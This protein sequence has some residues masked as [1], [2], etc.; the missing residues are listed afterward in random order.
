MHEID[1]KIVIEEDYE[2]PD[3]DAT[4]LKLDY[5]IESPVQRN[6]LVKKIVE[7]L[8]PQRLTN[9]YLEILADYIIFAMTKEE[10]K[11]KNINTDNRM[12]TINKREISFQGLVGK[13]ENGE[14]GIYNL[15]TEDKNIIFTPKISI[16]EEDLEEIPALRQLRAAIEQVEKL[17]KTARG[18]RK[19]L[20]KKQIIQMRQD[21]YVIKTSY[22]QPVYC[23][24]AV[25]NFNSMRFDDD[26][27][28][29]DCGRSFKR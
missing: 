8:P 1:D 7:S 29:K 25:K 2:S 28:R 23:L 22:K 12:V 20:L 26:M 24:N 9:R 18:R 19:Y 11:T 15:I 21:Q 5:T 14:D 3:A 17:A 16:T 4:Q 27:F 6:E 13:F 10:R